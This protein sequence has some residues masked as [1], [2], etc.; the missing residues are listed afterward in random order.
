MNN[1]T[2]QE[3]FNNSTNDSKQTPPTR[4]NCGT[5]SMHEKLLKESEEYRKER[6]KIE[7]MTE[8]FIK[9]KKQ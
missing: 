2:H 6:E 3:S 7:K 9:N 5:M 4:R 1:F 8:E